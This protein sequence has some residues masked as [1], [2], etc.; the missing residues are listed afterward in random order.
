MPNRIVKMG[1]T[2]VEVTLVNPSAPRKLT[3]SELIVDTGSILTWVSGARLEQV[4]MKP[5]RKK[6]F[7]TIEGRV[8]R[9]DTGPAIVRFDGSEADIEVVFAHKG[10]AEVLGVTAL[11]SL[12]YQV[13]PV[14][15]RLRHTG[16][17]AL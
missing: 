15:N 2:R 3:R 11:E 12:G 8:I 13:D 7:R 10:D 17:L 6:E 16:L 9:R 5:R 14:S 4:G 1:L